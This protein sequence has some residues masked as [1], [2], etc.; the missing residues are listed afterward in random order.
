MWVA[1]ENTMEQVLIELPSQVRSS[2]EIGYITLEVSGD[3]A[4]RLDLIRC[5]SNV[6][7]KSIKAAIAVEVYG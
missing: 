1:L 3:K 2:L 7:P 6:K 5:K 4:Q